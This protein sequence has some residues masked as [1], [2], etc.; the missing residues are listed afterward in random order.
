MKEGQRMNQQTIIISEQY[1]QYRLM[2]NWNNNVLLL[3]LLSVLIFTQVTSLSTLPKQLA[4][5]GVVCVCVFCVYCVWVLNVSVV[6]VCV[7]VLR[8]SV[9]LLVLQKLKGL[10]HRSESVLLVW[11]KKKKCSQQLLI[12]TSIYIV[13]WFFKV[14]SCSFRSVWPKERYLLDE[15]KCELQSL[16]VIKMECICE[17]KQN[18]H[19]FWQILNVSHH[20]FSLNDDFYEG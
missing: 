14:C 2:K 11:Q 17:S 20:D 5:V 15:L 10:P 19:C 4:C 16:G 1:L 7:C 12:L 13:S 6:C 18:A 3:Q 9:H 8:V